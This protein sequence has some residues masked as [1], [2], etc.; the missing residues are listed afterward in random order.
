[1]EPHK[2]QDLSRREFLKASGAGLMALAASACSANTQSPA[3]QATKAGSS[4]ADVSTSKGTVKLNVWWNTEPTTKAV[5]KEFSKQNPGIEITLVDIGETVFGNQKYLTAV[6]AGTGPDVAWQNRHTF[7]QFASRNL[8]RDVTELFKR[9]GLKAS[10]YYPTPFGE[11]TWQGKIYGL[12]LVTDARFLFWNKDHFKEA[13]L[14]PE[15]PPTNWNEL[16]LYAGKLNKKDGNRIERYGFLPWNVGNPYWIPFVCNDAP[17]IADNGRRIPSDSKEWVDALSWMVNF[18]D[19]YAGGAGTASGFLQGFQ[20]TALD[21]F[22]SGRLSMITNGNWALGTYAGLPH[23]KYGM[24]PY[25]VGPDAE[26][27]SNLSCGYAF[28]IDPHSEHVEEAWKFLRWITGP[29]GWR[30]QATVGAEISAAE[31][32]REQLPG[33]SIYV[34]ELA[35]NKAAAQMLIDEFASKLPGPIRNNYK[36]AVDALNQTNG[37]GQTGLAAL[38]YYNEIDRAVQNAI[39]HKATPEQALQQATA[40]AQQALDAAWA[41]VDAA[42][43]K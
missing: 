37:C 34:P 30:A 11:V 36:L 14:D 43:G 15:S 1:M 29:D 23:L 18:Y 6:A 28:V 19:K 3:P 39:N 38:E 26:G 40:K 17:L 9:D 12:P 22:A 4:S 10:D 2:K 33:E 21:P 27:K 32:K 24:A 20:N 35:V 5:V 41:R 42:Q 31:W 13:G 7:A 25:P 8:F 16:E